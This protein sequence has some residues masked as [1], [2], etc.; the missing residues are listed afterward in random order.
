MKEPR[1]ASITINGHVLTTAQAMTVRV[2]LSSFSM[3][4]QDEGCGDD[5]HGKLMTKGYLAAAAGIFN[6]M[7]DPS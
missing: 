3:T 7:K 2:A 5:E 4:L 6:Y 1:E